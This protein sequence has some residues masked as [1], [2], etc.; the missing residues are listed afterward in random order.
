MSGEIVSHTR[1][2]AIFRIPPVIPPRDA[3]D[4]GAPKVEERLGGTH[5][6]CTTNWHNTLIEPILRDHSE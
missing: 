5:A 1:Y 2:S 6:H 3:S 4:L